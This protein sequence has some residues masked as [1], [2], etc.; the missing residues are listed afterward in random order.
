MFIIDIHGET[1]EG[2]P[3]ASGLLDVNGFI[4]QLDPPPAEQVVHSFAPIPTLQQVLDVLPD[5]PAAPWRRDLFGQDGERCTTLE[6]SIPKLRREA[7]YREALAAAEEAVALRTHHQGPDHWEA[8][9]SKDLVETLQYITSLPDEAKNELAVVD[10][11][12]PTIQPLYDD[13]KMDLAFGAIQH[14][15]HVRIR[16]LGRTHEETLKSLAD[17]AD[18][19]Q[20]KGRYCDA[21]RVYRH[22]LVIQLR[23]TGFEDDRTVHTLLNYSQLLYEMGRISLAETTCRK[24]LWGTRRIHGDQ[25]RGVLLSRDHLANVLAGQGRLSFA[26]TLCRK[27]VE[28]CLRTGPYVADYDLRFQRSLAGILQSQGK[29]AE[30]EELYRAVVQS[31]ADGRGNRNARYLIHA[32][33]E[34]ATVLQGRGKLAESELLYRNTL[35]RSVSELGE[36]H[37]LSLGL[38]GNLASALYDQHKFS[39]AEPLY[40]TTLQKQQRLLGN[41]H[42]GTLTTMLGLGALRHSQGAVAEAESLYR[43]VFVITQ[44]EHGNDDLVGFRAAVA[45]ARFLQT[46]ER[47]QEAEE[48]WSIA[49]GLYERRRVQLSY[50]GLERASAAARLSPW[51]SL[52]V[53]RARIGKHREAWKAY[54]RDLARGLLDSLA[55]E[56]TWR[57]TPQERNRQQDLSWQL[58][59]SQEHIASLHAEWDMGADD[60]TP[61]DDLQRERQAVQA[62]FLSFQKTL[63]DRY[64]PSLGTPYSLADIQARLSADAAIV[65]WLDV[66]PVAT[67]LPSQ[68]EHWGCIVRDVGSPIWVKLPGLGANDTWTNDDDLVPE[69]LR[70]ILAASRNDTTELKLGVAAV[71]RQRLGPLEPYLNGITRLIVLPARSLAGIPI[72]ALTDRFVVSYAPS[73][74]MYAWLLEQARREARQTSDRRRA[75]L[76]ALG[77]PKFPGPNQSSPVLRPLPNTRAEVES[78][79]G[80]FRASGAPEPRLLFGSEAS[81]QRLNQL[82]ATGRLHD[83]RYLHFAT[84]GDMNDE[85]AMF[86][87][88]ILAP[89]ALRDPLDALRAGEEVFDGRLTAEQVCRTWKLNAELVTLSACETALGAQAGGEGYLGFAQAFLVAGA[90]SLV[91]SL[92]NV[93]DTATA[94]LMTRFYANLLGQFHDERQFVGRSYPPGLPMAKAAALGEAKQWLRRQSPEENRRVIRQMNLEES[95]DVRVQTIGLAAAADPKAAFDYSAPYYW[96]AFVLIGNDQ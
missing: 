13:G 18:M 48:V 65:G 56:R 46:V 96:A 54:E 62:E 21:D 68:G 63:E 92:W 75:T 80:L 59:R 41:E 33:S 34:L 4:A 3:I 15:V 82:A 14:Q 2:P 84:H 94:L 35:A 78:I 39:E 47:F 57:L 73:A 38:A 71:Y 31:R 40:V 77:D 29:Y 1:A 5:D 25:H 44:R 61:L 88:L 11:D 49:A 36:D 90:E 83:F 43:H 67:L 45:W 79:G 85:V 9:R 8:R 28:E 10:A 86:S 91:L 52:A 89:D 64:G 6:A 51:M 37:P 81:E 16:W 95:A 26:E 24:S 87:A 17:L 27:N 32:A 22:V 50:V 74:T 60:R 19:L 30:A 7:R 20:A 69:K 12:D 72:E 70:S 58:N 53:C 66:Q 76:L 55:M 93:D 42:V 23:A